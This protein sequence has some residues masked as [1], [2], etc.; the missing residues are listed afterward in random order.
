MGVPAIAVEEIAMVEA[1]IADERELMERVTDQLLCLASCGAM[2]VPERARRLSITAAC[3]R[4]LISW[5][6]K[7]SCH[8]RAAGE[9]GG[10]VADVAAREPPAVCQIFLPRQASGP[11]KC[12]AR[13]R[14]LEICQFDQLAF[15]LFK[16]FG[17]LA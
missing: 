4:V 9:V 13:W 17:F 15:G 8:W 2:T 5:N 3:D 10:W 14:R 16:L 1:A 6:L 11:A 7:S 12:L